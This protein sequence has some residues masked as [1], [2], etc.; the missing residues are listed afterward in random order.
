[1]KTAPVIVCLLATT[2]L[3]GCDVQRKALYCPEQ[4]TV[5]DVRK[6]AAENGLQLWPERDETYQGI[7]SR[8]GPANSKGTVMV[9]HGNSGP[10][11]FRKHYLPPLESRGY[12]VVLAE[13]PG[14]GGRAGELS[15]ES[16]VADARRAAL[17]AKTE[18]GKPLYLWGESMG[19]GVAAALAGDKLVRPDGIV[20][21][22]PWDSLLN[23]AV[24]K[25]P[26]FPVKLILRDSYDNAANL[27]GYKGPVA[28][29][30][31]GKDQVIPNRLTE[32]LYRSIC[33]PKRMWV[34]ENAGHND[35]PADPGLDWW[36]EVMDFVGAPN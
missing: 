29:I 13:Y 32:N 4:F 5:A 30:A 6:Y 20:L 8:S 1:M 31:A 3:W 17:R 11:V 23:I 10:A 24:E 9:F 14:Y 2:I 36:S 15:E 35:W 26:W 34:F 25:L 28:V 22:T 21:L 16:L 19:C 7:V 12:R 33:A 18:F 27:A